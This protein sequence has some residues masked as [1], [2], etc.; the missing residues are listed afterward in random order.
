MHLS[1]LLGPEF[2][3]NAPLPDADYQQYARLLTGGVSPDYL[4]F[5][6][7]HNG[8]EGPVGEENYVRLL[9]LDEVSAYHAACASLEGVSGYL[10]FASDGGN[11]VYAFQGA[12]A[13][14]EF[15]LIG[16]EPEEALYIAEDFTGFL[17]CLC[18]SEGE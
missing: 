10:I 11:T 7:A 8:G 1:A 14:V 4:V 16:L 17:A 5:M 9:R 12:E 6:R 13:V 18:S 3:R 15:D 2:E